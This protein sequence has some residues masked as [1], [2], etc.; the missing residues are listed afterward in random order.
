VGTKQVGITGVEPSMDQS[1]AEI[2]VI[3]RA[4]LQSLENTPNAGNRVIFWQFQ[5]IL[6]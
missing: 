2:L 6:N 1:M 5:N 4:S 3:H